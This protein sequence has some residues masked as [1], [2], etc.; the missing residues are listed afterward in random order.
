[1]PDS[2]ELVCA[3]ETVNAVSSPSKQQQQWNNEATNANE[4]SAA[5]TPRERRVPRERMVAVFATMLAD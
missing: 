4:M 3:S 2:S 1:L 5:S